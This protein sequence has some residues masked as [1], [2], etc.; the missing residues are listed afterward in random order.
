MRLPGMRE[1]LLV[2]AASKERAAKQAAEREEVQVQVSAK[3]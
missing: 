2:V 1:R 3:L